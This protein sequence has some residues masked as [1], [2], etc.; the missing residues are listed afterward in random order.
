[1]SSISNLPKTTCDFK[2]FSFC[3]S[4]KVLNVA[5]YP[6]KA[7]VFGAKTV[8]LS[9]RSSKE[10]IISNSTNSLYNS[11]SAVAVF[12]LVVISLL[13]YSIKLLSYG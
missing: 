8:N 5:L 4:I 2:N 10:S 11:S 13:E 3:E 1:M 6:I 12:A 7:F 9:L